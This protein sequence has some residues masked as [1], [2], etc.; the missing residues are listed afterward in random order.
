[1]TKMCV[2]VCGGGGGGGGGGQN[3]GAYLLT[4]KKGVTP[5]MKSLERQPL[6][7]DEKLGE[8]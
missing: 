6:Y 1:M 4:L 7:W 5:R 3:R 8:V 2:C